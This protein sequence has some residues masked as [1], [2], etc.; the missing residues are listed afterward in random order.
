MSD[1]DALPPPPSHPQVGSGTSADPARLLPSSAD[2]HAK[3]EKAWHHPP[4]HPAHHWRYAGRWLTGLLALTVAYFI[5]HAIHDYRQDQRKV[6]ADAHALTGGDPAKGP[7]LM[8]THGCAQCHT[9]PGVGG[10]TGLV[11]P[12]LSGIASRVYIAGVLTNTPDNL[13]KWIVNPKA[14]DAKT[15]M[16]VVGVT[17]EQARHIAAYLYTLR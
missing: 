9:I 1:H 14:I 8:R 13:V 2:S 16:P 3:P 11:G 15:A 7:G 6:L 4:G 17:E 10:A 5:G 12:P